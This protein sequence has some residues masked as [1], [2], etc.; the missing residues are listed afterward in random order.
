MSKRNIEAFRNALHSHQNAEMY[1]DETPMSVFEQACQTPNCGEFIK[2]C[3]VAGCDVNKVIFYYCLRH[4]ISY[5]ENLLIS[6]FFK[7]FLMSA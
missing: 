6:R 1:D 2:E 3:I 7:F 5:A 4:S